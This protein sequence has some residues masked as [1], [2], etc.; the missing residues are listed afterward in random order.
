MNI[1][2]DKY[3]KMLMVVCFVLAASLVEAQTELSTTQNSNFKI[4]VE[5]G[6]GYGFK[7]RST[8]KLEGNYSSSGMNYTLRLKWGSG[9]IFGAGIETGYLTVS[10]IESAN[11]TTP[12]GLTNISASL[13]AI[14]LL[15]FVTTQY[16][17]FQLNTGLGYYNV[18]STSTVFNSTI[19]SN[20][21]DFGY[22]ISLGYSYPINSTFKFGAEIKW[23]NIS[24]VQITNLSLQIKLHMLL[25]LL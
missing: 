20:E 14:P 17:N 24:E 12:L 5:L 15:F 11:Q 9:S 16:S 2:L 6:G 23:N 22:M 8:N 4:G 19:E 21:W 1:T 7:L 18:R 3:S 13:N 10:S 25:W